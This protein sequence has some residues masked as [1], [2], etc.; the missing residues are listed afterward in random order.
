MDLRK[1]LF[2]ATNLSF[3]LVSRCEVSGSKKRKQERKI[4]KAREGKKIMEDGAKTASD[5][6]VFDVVSNGFCSFFVCS[7]LLFSVLSSGRV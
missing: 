1:C 6:L 4:G 3:F 5:G 7:M 2:F